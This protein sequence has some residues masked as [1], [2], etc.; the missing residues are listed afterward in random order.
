MCAD[1]KFRIFRAVV[2]E[3][4]GYESERKVS[5][6]IT[7]ELAASSQNSI[8]GGSSSECQTVARDD[9]GPEVAVS[10]SQNSLSGSTCGCSEILGDEVLPDKMFREELAATSGL[11]SSLAT[12]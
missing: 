12:A 4:M 9:V 2:V 6:D 8:T 7:S 1:S 11:T 3:K 10:S 5:C